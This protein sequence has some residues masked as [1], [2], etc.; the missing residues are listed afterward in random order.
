[1]AMW[2]FSMLPASCG[3]PGPVLFA[4]IRSAPLLGAP[5]LQ[6]T[7]ARSGSVLRLGCFDVSVARQRCC[8]AA[9][10]VRRASLHQRS[11]P[12]RYY[13]SGA[14]GSEPGG[15]GNEDEVRA[16]L[17]K[18]KRADLQSLAKENNIPANKK[19]SEI[20]EQLIEAR[21]PGALLLV[22]PSVRDITSDVV[23]SRVEN[24]VDNAIVEEGDG[25]E[26][27]EEGGEDGL[28]EACDEA[29]I[30]EAAIELSSQLGGL[31]AVVVFPTHGDF[32]LELP[33]MAA[34]FGAQKDFIRG[35]LK[36]DE[37][38]FFPPHDMP[39]GEGVIGTGRQIAV[40]QRGGGFSFVKKALLA[41]VGEQPATGCTALRAEC[42][43]VGVLAILGSCV[44][45]S[46]CECAC[47]KAWRTFAQE[48]TNNRDETEKVCRGEKK[49][50]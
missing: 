26:E 7:A 3:S 43:G 40:M 35:A 46:I 17:Q 4:P 10:G 14:A 25:M 11:R 42:N 21:D 2:C 9:D 31:G 23:M 12:P 50:S 24:G 37:M 19:S 22:Q 38:V 8:N 28:E 33:V 20:I 30:G 1:M 48:K 18:L 47:A 15:S 36:A 13:L 6:G 16:F 34:E 27:S 32:E 45:A 5:A 29:E 41:Q 49:A 39:A 44:C